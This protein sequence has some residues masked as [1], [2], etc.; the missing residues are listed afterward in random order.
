M[1]KKFDIK[2]ILVIYFISI[3][4]KK[5]SFLF[6]VFELNNFDDINILYM[7]YMKMILLCYYNLI[8]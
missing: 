8:N 3:Y 6:D 4:N 2:N 5:S 1:V 7:Y